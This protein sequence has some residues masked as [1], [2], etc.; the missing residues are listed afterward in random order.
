MSLS[1]TM[2]MEHMRHMNQEVVHQSGSSHPDHEPIDDDH[3]SDYVACDCIPTV[4]AC[5]P[6]HKQCYQRCPDQRWGWMHPVHPASDT[7]TLHRTERVVS[8]CRHCTP[9]H[10][11]CQD[12]PVHFHLMSLCLTSWTRNRV[13]RNQSLIARS[14]ICPSYVMPTLMMQ[15]SMHCYYFPLRMMSVVVM[16]MRM[17]HL[18]P[19]IHHIVPW[20]TTRWV[21]HWID[22]FA[23]F[24][25]G[26]VISCSW[27]S[28]EDSC[29]KWKNHQFDS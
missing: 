13:S 6:M 15:L 16:M 25:I 27:L 2:M 5:F 1:L 19:E 14:M 8:N 9:L 11:W 17:M 29:M 28:F 26:S 21:R 4:R 22:L 3:R 23:S 20:N 12:L 24:L 10:P 7:K 18:R